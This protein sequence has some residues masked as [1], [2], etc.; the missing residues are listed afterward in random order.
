M[1]NI[2][3]VDDEKMISS[4]VTKVLIKSGHQVK[5]LNSGIDAISHLQEQR[6]TAIYYEIVFLDLLMPEISGADVLDWIHANSPNS[7]VIIMTAYGDPA[8]RMDLMQRGATLILS[9]PFDDIFSIPKL[10]E[11]HVGPKK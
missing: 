5:T 11:E 4:V 3:V 7:K 9:K 1:A 10:V 6:N 8:V 2:L